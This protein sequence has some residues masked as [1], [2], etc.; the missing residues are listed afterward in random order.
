MV[1]ELANLTNVQSRGAEAGLNKEPPTSME[2]KKPGKA[3]MKKV[4]GISAG[5]KVGKKKAVPPPAD[6]GVD[7]MTTSPTR[8]R[9]RSWT[10]W[11][12]T[13]P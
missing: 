12:T 7:I 8:T 6:A 2:K 1:S 5:V 9:R 10:P 13:A 4:T 3:K 11:T